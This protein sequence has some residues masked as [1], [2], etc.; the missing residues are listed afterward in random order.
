M[1]AIVEVYF[2]ELVHESSLV[3][4]VKIDEERIILP[5]S[6]CDLDEKDKVVDV[7]EWLAIEKE[8]V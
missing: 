3:W 4:I 7:P 8:L 1:E 5:K 2:D 6:I